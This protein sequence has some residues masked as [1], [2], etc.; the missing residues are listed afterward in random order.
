MRIILILTLSLLFNAAYAA[1]CL[2]VALSSFANQADIERTRE[3]TE[4]WNL[5]KNDPQFSAFLE[6]SKR[7]EE[8]EQRYQQLLR[9]SKGLPPL[10]QDNSSVSP[11]S[12]LDRTDTMP[13]KSPSTN[14]MGTI[15]DDATESMLGR[16]TRSDATNSLI[17]NTLMN[18]ELKKVEKDLLALVN[19][20]QSL[21]SYTRASIPSPPP[22]KHSLDL[23]FNKTTYSPND[24]IVLT[25]MPALGSPS[26]DSCNMKTVSNL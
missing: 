20:Y 18:Y 26:E 19:E 6:S 4:F 9:R 23:S 25:D 14:A 24:S 16:S 22:K 5:Y 21:P 13:D 3:A 7:V 1:N 15:P 8:I 12:I 11:L 2:S 17:D 10:P